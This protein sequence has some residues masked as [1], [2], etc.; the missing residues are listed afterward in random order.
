[1]KNIRFFFLS[2]HFHFLVVKFSVYLNMRVFV[3][4]AR[5]MTKQMRKNEKKQ[6]KKKKKK[7]TKKKKNTKK[8]TNKKNPNKQEMCQYDRVAPAQGTSS[9][10]IKHFAKNKLKKGHNSFLPLIFLDIYFMI[11]YMCIK[12]E[13]NALIFSKDHVSSIRTQDKVEK[14]RS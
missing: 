4:R 12:Y 1:M 14:K 10:G 13:S 5:K 3:M 11:I 2:E 9:P 7:K 8:K 6:Q